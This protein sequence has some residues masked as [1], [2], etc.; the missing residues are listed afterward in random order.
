MT[1]P[2]ALTITTNSE[3]AY[4]LAEKLGFSDKMEA[5]SISLFE[6]DTT[7]FRVEAL[8]ATE[9]EAEDAKDS[10]DLGAD[11]EVSVHK[12]ADEDWVSLSQKGLSPV[13]A[14]RF[15]VHGSHDRDTIP[16]NTP[17]PILI[18]AGLAFGTGHHGT[19]KG[20]LIIYDALLKTEFNPDDILDLGC[21]AGTL[22]ISAAMTRSD[23][24]R[25]LATDMDQD[26][27]DVTIENAKLNGVRE[28]IDVALADGFDAPVFEKRSFDLIFANIL[29]GPLMTLASDIIQVMKPNSHV[30]LS[31]IID[32]LSQD[33]TICFEGQGLRIEPQPSIEGWTSL[34]GTKA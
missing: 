22:A 28:H 29:A 32:E 15:W 5:L 2:Y 17:F 1:R 25:I 30:I 34:L 31:G 14:G 11:I 12:T 20:C 13:K 9:V 21:G 6:L 19:T 7:T 27:V 10:L 33:V 3:H 24:C 16:P 23:T 18:D 4:G 26:A 8:Y